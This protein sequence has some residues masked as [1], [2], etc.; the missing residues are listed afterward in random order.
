MVESFDALDG[1][2]LTGVGGA[3][4]WNSATLLIGRRR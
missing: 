4:R 2:N 3:W 1:L